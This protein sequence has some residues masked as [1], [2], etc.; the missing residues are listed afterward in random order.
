M[1]PRPNPNPIPTHPSPSEPPPPP[2]SPSP[3]PQVLHQSDSDEDDENVKQLQECSSLYLSLQDCLIKSNRN[4]KA[5]QTEVQ[6]LKE[7]NERRKS[8]KKK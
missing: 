1:D 8:S 4:W 6:A 7:C 3:S 5:C 2:P